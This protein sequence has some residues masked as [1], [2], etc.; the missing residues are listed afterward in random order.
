MGKLWGLVALHADRPADM[1]VR[2]RVRIARL[3]ED[4]ISRVIMNDQINE[5]MIPGLHKIPVFGNLFKNK[6]DFKRH[7][8]LLIFI[9]PRIVK[10]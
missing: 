1:T 4:R 10:Y 2:E 3:V 8:E 7:D 6:G 5:N 9:T